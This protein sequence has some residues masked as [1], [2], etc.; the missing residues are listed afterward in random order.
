MQSGIVGA[1]FASGNSGNTTYTDASHDGVTNPASFCTTDGVSS[2]QICNSHT[3]NV[4]DDDGGYIQ[5]SARAYYQNPIG[6]GG[7]G[8][9]PT[10]TP[11]ATIP[12]STPTATVSTTP[13][14]S[15]PT[16]AATTTSKPTRTPKPRLTNTPLPV[17]ATPTVAPTGFT[18]SASLAPPSVARGA[19]ET[20]SLTVKSATATSA[21]VDVEVYN[22]SGVKVFQQSWDG[23]SFSA[24]QTGSY[25]ANWSVPSTLAPGTYSVD[26]GVFYT[27]WSTLYDWHN[28]AATLTVV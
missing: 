15:T 8:G 13:P 28:N 21:L 7:G 20:V 10:S 4:S 11:T 25:S 9:Q 19:Q 24:S 17:T 5:M 27:G 2:G 23:Q 26:I 3:S 18:T 1:I 12:T 16:R 14:T 22:S 6:L